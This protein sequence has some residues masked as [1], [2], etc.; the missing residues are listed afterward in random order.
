[1][2]LIS[3]EVRDVVCYH[4]FFIIVMVPFQEL[5]VDGDLLL[6]ITDEDLRNDLGMS[7]GLTRKRYLPAVPQMCCGPF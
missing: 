1:M 2:L 3:R 5:Q 4:G 6:N 7:S